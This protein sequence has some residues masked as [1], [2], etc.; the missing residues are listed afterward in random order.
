MFQKLT[1]AQD[2]ATT[3]SV[4]QW[5]FQIINYSAMLIIFRIIWW[6]EKKKR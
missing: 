1:N 3:S 5:W 4:R 6:L 2:E